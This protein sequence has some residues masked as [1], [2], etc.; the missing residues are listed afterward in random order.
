MMDTVYMSGELEGQA[1]C[2]EGDLTWLSFQ[3]AGLLKE[4]CC[5]G[6]NLVVAKVLA[7]SG[8]Y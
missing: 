2:F 4:T 8:C 3:N 6:F 1:K 7:I 5:F